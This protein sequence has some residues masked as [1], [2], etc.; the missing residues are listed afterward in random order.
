[1]LSDCHILKLS[2]LTWIQASLQQEHVSF[3]A[4][5]AAHTLAAQN[6]DWNLNCP[7]HPLPPDESSLSHHPIRLLAACR[8]TW[9]PSPCPRCAATPPQSLRAS[10]GCLG[11][12]VGTT[13]GP[14]M[15]WG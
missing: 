14:P 11:A 6:G 15:H 2:S 12:G 8:S 10:S 3:L 13:L 9:V 4:G 5:F 7:G 1:V